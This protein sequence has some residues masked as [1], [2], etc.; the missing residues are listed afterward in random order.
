[1]S[2]KVLV[3]GAQLLKDWLKAHGI[4]QRVFSDR[5]HASQA[6]ISNILKGGT[7]PGLALAQMIEHGTQFANAYDLELVEPVPAE[8]WFT[9]QESQQIDELKQTSEAIKERK[10]A[11]V[12]ELVRSDIAEQL[13]K[14][15]AKHDQ[16]VLKLSAQAAAKEQRRYLDMVLQIRQQIEAMKKAS[17]MN[18]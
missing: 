15:F 1:M 5:V 3:E 9:P 4:S 13:Q 16:A 10:R 2:E 8:S 7:R 17:E 6:T 18:E 12:R 11:Y 14:L